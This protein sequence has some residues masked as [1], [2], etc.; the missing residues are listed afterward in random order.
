[1]RHCNKIFSCVCLFLLLTITGRNEAI[2]VE[3]KALFVLNGTFLSPFPGFPSLNLLKLITKNWCQLW[4][5]ISQ[6]L[7]QILEEVSETGM[8]WPLQGKFCSVSRSKKLINFDYLVIKIE[9]D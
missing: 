8:L 6:L 4:P 9:I 5:L 2:F 3:L 1:M 7:Q